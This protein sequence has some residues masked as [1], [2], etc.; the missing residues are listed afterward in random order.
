MFGDRFGPF[1]LL[2]A[3]DG[4]NGTDCIN[5]PPHD[6]DRVE[7]CDLCCHDELYSLSDDVT[8]KSDCAAK[9]LCI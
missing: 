4:Y 5:D 2:V 9:I 1:M 3:A 7:R 6:P 8:Y